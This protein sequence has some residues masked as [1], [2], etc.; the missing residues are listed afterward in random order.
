[1]W[2][3]KKKPD[4]LTD[5]EKA[6]VFLVVYIY[7]AKCLGR[8]DAPP[9]LR[10]DDEGNVRRFDSPCGWHYFTSV[11]SLPTADPDNSGVSCVQCGGELV[12]FAQVAKVQAKSEKEALDHVLR[13]RNKADVVAATSKAGELLREALTIVEGLADGSPLAVLGMS[14]ESDFMPSNLPTYPDTFS[15]A[16]D[17]DD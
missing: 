16:D 8:G 2:G 15:L 14:V 17:E 11:K 1:M 7:R 13:T 6:D 12:G 10:K 4:P 5:E 9:L 3:K